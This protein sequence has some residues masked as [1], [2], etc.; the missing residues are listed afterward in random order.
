[1]ILSSACMPVAA[2]L[3]G[4]HQQHAGYANVPGQPAATPAPPS[5][6]PQSSRSSGTACGVS[7]GI[8]RERAPNSTTL[9]PTARNQHIPQ[10]RGRLYL[11]RR[12]SRSASCHSRASSTKLSYSHR[13]CATR[14]AH[15]SRGRGAPERG[16][17]GERV[18][19]PAL[20][21]QRAHGIPQHPLAL[22]RRQAVLRGGAHCARG[23][24]LKALCK[25]AAA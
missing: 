7:L 4:R 6:P 16:G 2:T 3:P 21:R 15:C 20:F 13:A 9:A 17:V 10:R 11:C 14:G 5:G 23:I 19:L 1:M 18:R 8:R 22:L 12:R 25:G 24:T